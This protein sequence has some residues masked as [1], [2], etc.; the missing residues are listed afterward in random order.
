VFVLNYPFKVS[1]ERKKKV[2]HNLVDILHIIHELKYVSWVSCSMV[3]IY[4]YLECV[5][6]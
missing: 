1:K 3:I 6:I 4:T 5:K 2:K